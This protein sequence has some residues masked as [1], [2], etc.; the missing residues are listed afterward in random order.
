MICLTKF[1]K[2]GTTALRY[3]ESRSHAVF[4]TRTIIDTQDP[5]WEEEAF[6]QLLHTSVVV[7]S[8]VQS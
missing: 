1:R 5:S 8:N 4:S 6:G 7:H 2:P 3:H